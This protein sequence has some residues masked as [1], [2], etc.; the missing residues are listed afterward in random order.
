M[1]KAEE[2]ESRRGRMMMMRMVWR[3]EEEG[4]ELMWEWKEGKKKVGWSGVDWLG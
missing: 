1:E 2:E 3:G 4:W